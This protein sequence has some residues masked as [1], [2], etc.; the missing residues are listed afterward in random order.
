MAKAIINLIYRGSQ[1]EHPPGGALF[2]KS[3]MAAIQIG[4]I[5]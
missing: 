3:K 2:D 5:S 4:V 1:A